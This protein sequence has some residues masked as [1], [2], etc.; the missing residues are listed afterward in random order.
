LIVVVLNAKIPPAFDVRTFL[1][2]TPSYTTKNSLP[3]IVVISGRDTILTVGKNVVGLLLASYPT[4]C[5]L[6]HWSTD[7]ALSFDTYIPFSV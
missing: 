1:L 4:T 5:P 3:S 2:L 7:S 6:T